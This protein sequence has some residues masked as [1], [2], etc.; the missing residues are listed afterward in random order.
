M[1][2]SIIGKSFNFPGVGKGQKFRAGTYL[3]TQVGTR[4]AL[5]R[6]GKAFSL[7]PIHSPEVEDPH[8]QGALPPALQRMTCS[9]KQKGKFY[10]CWTGY[11]DHIYHSPARIE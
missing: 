2:L 3:D 10:L 7:V 6:V 8:T 1:L 4:Q 11:F 5:A 9:R